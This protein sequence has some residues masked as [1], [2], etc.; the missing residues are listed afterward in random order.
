MPRAERQRL[1]KERAERLRRR[2]PELLL[3]KLFAQREALL[4]GQA[5]IERLPELRALVRVA[6]TTSQARIEFGGN[7][8]VVRRRLVFSAIHTRGGRHLV[9]FPGG[10]FDAR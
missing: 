5:C 10:I 6:R 1:R 8:F 3:R 2:A 7:L 9:G 4:R